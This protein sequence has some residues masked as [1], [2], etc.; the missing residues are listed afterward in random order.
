MTHR[1]M[2]NT[3]YTQ[4]RGIPREIFYDR[5]EQEKDGNKNGE[6]TEKFRDITPTDLVKFVPD[7]VMEEIAE[8]METIFI[9]THEIADEIHI[10]TMIQTSD[11]HYEDVCDLNGIA[12]PSLY[13]DHICSQY[14]VPIHMGAAVLKQIIE[15]TL[16]LT[17]EGECSYLKRLELP[18]PCVS[19]AD[20]LFLANAFVAA[21]EKLF[22]KLKQIHREDYTWLTD[23]IVAECFK[24]LDLHLTN[25]NNDGSMP[26]IE[27]PISHY[28]DDVAIGKFNSVLSSHFGPEEKRF[29]FAAR[30]DL[31][32]DRTIWELKCTSTLSIEHKLQVVLYDWIWRTL[33]SPNPAARRPV[34]FHCRD[35]RLLNIRTGECFLLNATYEQLTT[36]VVALLK[37]KYSRPEIRTDEEFLEDSREAIQEII[38]E[39][40]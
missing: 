4:F 19:P 31:V 2:A 21:K 14:N 23:E 38:T 29:R 40:K 18:D 34:F 17:K 27:F 15:E 20:Y 35:A 26:S 39:N 28:D 11:G 8:L 32:T 1:E 5:Q 33:N 30:A 10:P 24:K 37:G 13:Y 22:F 12:I 7:H 9:Q 25:E 36:I 6:T 16:K 3:E